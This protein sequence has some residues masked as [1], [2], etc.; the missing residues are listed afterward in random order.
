MMMRM[1]IAIV[2]IGLALTAGFI[3][4]QSRRADGI[5]TTDAQRRAYMVSLF[6]SSSPEGAFARF[7]NGYADSDM[8]TQHLGAHIYGEM[9]YEREGIEAF[10]VCDASFGFGCFHSFIASAISEQG[11]DIVKELDEACVATHG[12]LG[13]GCPHGIGHGLVSYEGYSEGAL[14][15]SLDLCGTLAWKGRFGGCS[16]GVF[17]EYNF[18]MMET[19]PRD[20]LRT[21]SYED[22]HDPCLSVGEEWKH[23]C[24]YNQ[25]AWWIATA[26]SDAGKVVNAYCSEIAGD[27]LVTTCFRG[28]GAA[29]VTQRALDARGA[30]AYCDALPTSRENTL[31]CR[32]GVAWS[33]YANPDSRTTVEVACSEGLTTEES[34]ACRANHQFFIQ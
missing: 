26:P 4:L 13:L 11:E 1:R 29:S 19:D 24:Y 12:V 30:I 34:A 9:L 17:M 5:G 15:K 23:S 18:R 16:D 31:A 22:R 2:F 3:F 27:D 10:S 28:V 33:L 8:P 7:K 21:F 25:V 32:E 20:R 14:L 6:E